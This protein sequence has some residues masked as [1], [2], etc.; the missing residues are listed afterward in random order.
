MIVELRFPVP[1]AATRFDFE[2][3]SRRDHLDI[4]SV[5]SAIQLRVRDDRI[6][7]AHAAAGSVAPIPLYLQ[8]TSAFL[9]GRPI[10]AATAR[11]AAVVAGGEISPISDVR[12]SADYKRDLLQRLISIHFLTMFPE[13]IREEDLG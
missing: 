9:H 1:E 10:S 4:A 11:T 8:K 2:K 12:G 3:V 5:N 6:V 13:R 7:E